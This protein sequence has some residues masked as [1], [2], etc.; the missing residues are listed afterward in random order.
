MLTL[1]SSELPS[2][3]SSYLLE[4]ETTWR[5]REVRLQRDFEKSRYPTVQ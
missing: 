2:K 4:K 3:G 5:G 1:G